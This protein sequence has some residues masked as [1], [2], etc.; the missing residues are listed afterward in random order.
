MQGCLWGSVKCKAVAGQRT[1]CKVVFQNRPHASRLPRARLRQQTHVRT[2]CTRRLYMWQWSLCSISSFVHWSMAAAS[3]RSTDILPL[4]PVLS[5]CLSINRISQKLL[6]KSVWDFTE[7]FSDK[8]KIIFVNNSIP[9][10]SRASR[11]KL[12]S[13]LFNSLNNT[14]MVLGLTASE[15]DRDQRS[16]G[17]GRNQIDWNSL[18]SLNAI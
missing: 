4:P 1:T 14:T 5:V 8:I 7:R 2:V 13:S 18:K 11:R 12:K 15:S 10:W 3:I 17:S 16:E 6:I 9:S